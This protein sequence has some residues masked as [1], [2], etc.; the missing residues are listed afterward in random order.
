MSEYVQVTLATI[1]LLQKCNGGTVG[2]G[3]M[4]VFRMVRRLEREL[5]AYLTGGSE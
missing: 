3:D 5:D 2:T 1:A 4:I